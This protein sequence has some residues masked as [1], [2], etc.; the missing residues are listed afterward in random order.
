M[1]AQAEG[2]SLRLGILSGVGQ[3]LRLWL[4][5]GES[6]ELQPA[7]ARKWLSQRGVGCKENLATRTSWCR[8]W[9]GGMTKAV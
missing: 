9:Q 7:G 2:L 4:R 6:Q 5:E 1:F 8:H 3:G